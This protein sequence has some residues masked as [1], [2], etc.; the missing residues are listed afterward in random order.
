MFEGLWSLI[1]SIAEGLWTVFTAPFNL[2]ATVFNATLGQLSFTIPDWV[3]FVGGQ[4]WGIPKIP[5]LAEGTDNF[6]G[7]QAIVGE[8][9]PEM[10]NLP[11]GAEVIPNDKLQSAEKSAST[12]K[13]AGEEKPPIIKLI[14]NEREL[15]EAVLDVINKKL[16]VFS[17]FS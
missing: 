6:K 4:E 11:K 3:P 2:I 17:A 14:L 13:A 8:K 15:G 1:K 10:V 12:A 7:G 16:D 9:G 5:L